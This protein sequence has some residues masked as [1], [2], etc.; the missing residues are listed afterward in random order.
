MAFRIFPPAQIELCEAWFATVETTDEWTDKG[1]VGEGESGSIRVARDDGLLGYAKPG[2]PRADGV[3]RAA[4]EKIAFDLA[5]LLEFPVPPVVLWDRGEGHLD[6]RYLSISAHAF[7]QCAKWD[8]AM[9]LGILTAELLQS[10]SRTVSAMRAFHTWISDTDR[11]SDHTYVDLAS[12]HELGMAFIDHAFSLSYVWK[13]DDHAAG[14]CLGYMPTP[15]IVGVVGE[16]AD[17]IAELP[18]DRITDI[19]NRVPAPYLQDDA[20]KHIL[21]NLLSRKQQLRAIL[22][23]P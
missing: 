18:V 16:A 5:H 4:H 20:R 21:S 1:A 3:P 11:K 8:F 2:Q 17:R 23:I 10:A 7:P 9:N 12:T 19:V 22:A 6:N 13:R 15:E 14:P